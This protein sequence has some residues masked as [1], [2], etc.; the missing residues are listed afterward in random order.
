[1]SGV[2]VVRGAD[3]AVLWQEGRGHRTGRS[4]DALSPP[5]FEPL[6]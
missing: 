6:D 4:I 2:T 3:W 1:M 5:T